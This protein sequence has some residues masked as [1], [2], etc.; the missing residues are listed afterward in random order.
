MWFVLRS[1]SS[2]FIV[3]AIYTTED[4]YVGNWTKVASMNHYQDPG[5]LVDDDGKVYMYSGCSDNGNIKA[6][7]LSNQTWKEIGTPVDA[8]RPDFK[9]RGFEVGGDNNEQLKASPWVEG[10]FMNKI[11]GKYYL[12]YAVPGTQYKS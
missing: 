5:M 9:N 12:Q 8:V 4:P 1:H 3:A 6:V 11:N 2:H 10:A 7:E